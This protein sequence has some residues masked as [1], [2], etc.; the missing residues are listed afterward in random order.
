MNATSFPLATRQARRG[1]TLI[2]LLTVI[3]IIGI[4]AAIIIPTVGTVR[5]SARESKNLSNI[6]QLTTALNLYANDNKDRYPWAGNN[7]PST[8]STPPMQWK[9]TLYGYLSGKNATYDPFAKDN[10]FISPTAANETGAPGQSCQ[11]SLAPA[12]TS[13]QGV[14]GPTGNVSPNARLKRGNVT[15]PSQ[16]ILIADGAQ[17]DSSG[18]NA[19][20]TFYSPN[21][22]IYGNN[23]LLT[24][25]IPAAAAD[26]VDT[27]RGTLRYR[28]RDKVHVGMVDGSTRAIQRGE[29]TY[30]NIVSYQ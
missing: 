6:R 12:F 17:S 2:E 18:Q 10:V 21:E 7:T 19:A 26:N 11:Y 25:R 13:T 29:V 3:A 16:I 14:T 27:K 24:E 1:F 5:Q 22:T 30:G 9:S 4:L 20:E 28:N 8:E 23:R 15:R